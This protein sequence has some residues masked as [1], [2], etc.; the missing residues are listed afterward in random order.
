[1]FL[2]LQSA[3]SSYFFSS[4][5]AQ[6]HSL[7][8]TDHHITTTGVWSLPS[9][10]LNQTLSSLWVMPFTLFSTTY[11]LYVSIGQMLWALT[12]TK[13]TFMAMYKLVS[14]M[15]APNPST[16]R[17]VQPHHNQFGRF[18]TWTLVLE[19]IQP[20]LKQ[21]PWSA[22]TPRCLRVYK[23]TCILWLRTK[24]GRNGLLNL[25][26]RCLWNTSCWGFVTVWFPRAS[27]LSSYCFHS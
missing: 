7:S 27:S 2:H 5:P 4:L 14:T 22:Q 24:K 19:W 13:V 12:T 10:D 18:S 1:M 15:Y 23:P 6:F 11:N 21:G 17:R 25:R 3:S 16:W 20:F 26:T 8:Q 9:I